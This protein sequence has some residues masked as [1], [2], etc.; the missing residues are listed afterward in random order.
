MIV[1]HS[2]LLTNCVI[3]VLKMNFKR[4][5]VIYVFVIKN[6]NSLMY[7]LWEQFASRYMCLVKC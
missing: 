7:L 1:N 5:L 3:L 6:K 4:H 2:E